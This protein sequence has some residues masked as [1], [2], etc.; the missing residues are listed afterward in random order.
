MVTIPSSGET[1]HSEAFLPAGRAAEYDEVIDAMIGDLNVN[2]YDAVHSGI[3]ALN[4][5]IMR[6]I[7]KRI[8]ERVVGH[9]FSNE[10]MKTR[11]LYGAALGYGK[12]TQE[13]LRPYVCE[14]EPLKT[15]EGMF[16]VDYRRR[17]WK[18]YQ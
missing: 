15:L 5:D 10:R 11:M 13:I 6:E 8:T 2:N 1:S 14:E 7:G 18:S 9:I 12:E 16:M 3:E 17:L 4:E